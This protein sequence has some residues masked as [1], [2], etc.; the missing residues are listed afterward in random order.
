MIV[1]IKD[2]IG[3]LSVKRRKSKKTKKTKKR[4]KEGDR[5]RRDGWGLCVCV[6]RCVSV[7]RRILRGEV[8]VSG[9]GKMWKGESKESTIYVE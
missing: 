9:S 6:C 2:K 1:V 4:V 7:D 8:G 5:W 3:R